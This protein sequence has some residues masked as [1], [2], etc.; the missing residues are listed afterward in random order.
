MPLENQSRRFNGH[1]V[2]NVGSQARDFC[3]LDR[4]ILSHL[5]LALLLSLLSSSILL[6]SRL[7]PDPTEHGKMQPHPA[8]AYLLFGASIVTSAAGIWEFHTGV[9]DLLN[10]TA[11]L[12]SARIHHF[13]M[14]VVTCVVGVMCIYALVIDD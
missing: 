7:V 8:L 10:L 12:R 5:K 6:Q 13:L 4:N 2:Q 11:F 9:L 3:M 1:Y 14:T